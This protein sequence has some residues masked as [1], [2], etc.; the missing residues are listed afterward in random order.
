MRILYC[1]NFYDIH[2]EKWAKY[3]EQHLACSG[4]LGLN[5]VYNFHADGFSFKKLSELKYV[6]KTWKPDVLHCQYMGAWGLLGVLSGFRP[7]IGTVHGSEVLL[8][9]GF[10]RLLVRWILNRCTVITTDGFHV[11]QAMI[12]MG[13]PRLKINMVNF[14]VDVDRFRPKNCGT[15]MRVIFRGGDGKVYDLPTM[16]KAINIVGK[17]M[18]PLFQEIKGLDPDR[19]PLFMQDAMIYVSTATSDAGLASTTAEAMA[20]GLPVVITDVADNRH[21]VENGVSGFLFKPGDFKDLAM[22]ISIL[23]ESPDMRRKFGERARKIICERNNY[24]AEMG[25]MAKIYQEVING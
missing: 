25:K 16:E 3:F 14:G 2:S 8:S 20:C 13:V 7:I 22:K 9:R 6:I 12:G 10:K 23:L 18:A 15:I 17:R 1:A 24:F 19:I 4:R 5:D 21:W 11:R